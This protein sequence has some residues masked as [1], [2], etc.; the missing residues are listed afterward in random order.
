MYLI[1]FTKKAWL[2]DGPGFLKVE[3]SEPQNQLT[4]EDNESKCWHRR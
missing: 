4:M 3:V 1:I 2:E